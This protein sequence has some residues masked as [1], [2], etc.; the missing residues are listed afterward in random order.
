MSRHCPYC[1]DPADQP[2]VSDEFYSEPLGLAYHATQPDTVA[3]RACVI[4]RRRG[5]MELAIARA[6]LEQEALDNQWNP[7]RTTS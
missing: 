2:S 3:H 4:R 1:H 7:E 6:G 5:I